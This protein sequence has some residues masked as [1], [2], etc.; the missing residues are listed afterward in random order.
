MFF[1]EYEVKISLADENWI[2]C[3]N[4][5]ACMH[6]DHGGKCSSFRDLVSLITNTGDASIANDSNVLKLLSNPTKST[7]LQLKLAIT[8][9]V[10]IKAKSILKE[11]TLCIVTHEH[12]FFPRATTVNYP[13][14]TNIC[15]Q[16]SGGNQMLYQQ[17]HGNVLS[18]VKP[19]YNNFCLKFY[20]DLN[21]TMISIYHRMHSKQPPFFLS[22]HGVNINLPVLILK[23]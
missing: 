11:M 3:A 16:L 10:F 15:T 14:I 23:I 7:Q 5:Q 8:I 1:L 20:N 6:D 2:A 18:R 4:I 12:T 9:D 22:C 17:L 21:F 13:S 19:A